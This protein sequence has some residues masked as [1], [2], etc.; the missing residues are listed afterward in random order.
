[1]NIPRHAARKSDEPE[2]QTEPFVLE[3]F[4]FEYNEH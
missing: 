1:M 2:G 4:Q 3:I